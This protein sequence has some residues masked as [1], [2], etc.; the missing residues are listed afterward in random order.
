MDLSRQE[1]EHEKIL[2][3]WLKEPEVIRTFF[4]L[5]NNYK[6]AESTK[7]PLIS[8]LMKRS[9]VITIAMKKEVEAANFYKSLSLQ[10]KNDKARMVLEQ[11]INMEL[12]HKD[13]LENV[14][15]DIGF[16]EIL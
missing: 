3:E 5:S 14:L 4:T 7:L 15:A 1:K 10:T 13:I 12:A 9:D 2:R 6:I 8:P 16:T 11:L